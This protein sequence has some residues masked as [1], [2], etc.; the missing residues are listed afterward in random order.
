MID[1]RKMK[2]YSHYEKFEIIIMYLLKKAYGSD[3][4]FFYKSNT[5]NDRKEMPK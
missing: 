4:V 3:N 1:I 2:N 5:R